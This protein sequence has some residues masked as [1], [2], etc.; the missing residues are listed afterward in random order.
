MEGCVPQQRLGTP[1]EAGAIH[2]E[3][4][5]GDMAGIVGQQESGDGG[6][7]ETLKIG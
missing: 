3:A 6:L 1:E 5:R 4:L 2:R 7:L